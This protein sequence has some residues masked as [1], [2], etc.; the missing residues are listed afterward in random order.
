MQPLRISA[1]LTVAVAGAAVLVS[2]SRLEY[3]VPFWQVILAD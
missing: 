1:R 2:D 3:L